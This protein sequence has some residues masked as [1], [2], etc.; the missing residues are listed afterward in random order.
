MDRSWIHGSM[1]VARVVWRTVRLCVW[2]LSFSLLLTPGLSAQEPVPSAREEHTASDRDAESGPESLGTAPE[3]ETPRR[4]FPPEIAPV[5]PDESVGE[6]VRLGGQVVFRLS[7]GAGEISAG[8]RA[9]IIN[10]RLQHLVDDPR[11]SPADFVVG[12][13]ERTGLPYVRHTR[14]KR[15]LFTVYPNDGGARAPLSV[16]SDWADKLEAALRYVRAQQEKE[17]QRRAAAALR[18]ANAQ[19][20]LHTL[21]HS[22]LLLLLFYL[23]RRIFGWVQQKA[24]QTRRI[25]SGLKFRGIEIIT[26]RQVRGALLNLI[27]LLWISVYLVML[28]VYVQRVLVS[29]PATRSQGDIIQQTFLNAVSQIG[30]G[31]V[32]A[33]PDLIHIALILVLARLFLRG[34]EFVMFQAEQGHVSLEPYVPH[35]LIR[36]TRSVGKFLVIVGAL[37][38]IAPR[39]PGAGTDVGK[40]LAV[41]I[42]AVVSFSS[43]AT[44]GNF[45]AG[46]VIA[47][48]RP[49]RRGDRVK[50]GDSV[51]DVVDY[52][53]VYTRLRTPKNEEI[54]LPNLQVLNS[55]IINYSAVPEGLILHTTVTIG[56]DV[57]RRTVERLLMEAALRTEGCL[58]EPRPFVLIKSLDDFYVTYEINAHTQDSSAQAQVYSRL[59]QNIKDAFDAANVEI[60]SPHYRAMRDGN[61]VTIPASSA[62]ERATVLEDTFAPEARERFAEEKRG[63]TE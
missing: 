44:I 20:I 39:L 8:E 22:L 47:Y 10:T 62:F 45:M 24:K 15:I 41:L 59:H 36:P 33:I 12:Q 9:A 51:G 6:E 29:F 52:T 35:D 50:M 23:V 3:G 46:L 16:A 38:F 18:R 60:M 13:D 1:N 61:A 54:L 14:F 5:T 25:R 43:T 55:P 37:L 11:A 26:S 63:A 2:A 32:G 27:G 34:F 57:P 42:G 21:L 58:A 49:F 17:A 56:Y 53:F 48:M 31:I 4:D 7:Q 40:I 19:G 30:Q 28:A